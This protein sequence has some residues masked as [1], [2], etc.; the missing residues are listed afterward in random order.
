MDLLQ[1]LTLYDLLGYVLPGTMLLWLYQ[2]DGTLCQLEKMGELK[3]GYWIVLL[4]LGYLIGIIIS[5]IVEYMITIGKTIGKKIGKK[6]DDY[7]EAIC[8]I[9]GISKD[10]LENALIKSKVL[11]GT[12]S[13]T[14]T[15]EKLLQ[16]YESYI[17]SDIQVDPKY[18]RIH[19]YASAELL[20]KNM[21][22]VSVI[23][24]GIGI[25]QQLGLKIVIGL[26]GIFGFGIRG[27]RFVERRLG[28]AI[29]WFLQ[30]YQ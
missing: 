24:I 25:M 7:W 2:W 18:S 14:E 8:N 5:E 20:Y 13:Q 26:F 16:K 11:N 29:C 30:K 6:E 12:I 4:S 1:K 21:V 28:Y 3:L 10:R 17:F 22:A 27:K 23:I 15:K 19:N 9:Y